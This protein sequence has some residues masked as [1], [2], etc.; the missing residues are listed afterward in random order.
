MNYHVHMH[1]ANPFFR[2]WPGSGGNMDSDSAVDSGLSQ[3]E[4]SFTKRECAWA[5]DSA[6]AL[7]ASLMH[8]IL[9]ETLTA[10]KPFR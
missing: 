1:R 5:M 6:N 9:Y 7:L 10:A 8:V 2:T 3:R 4:P